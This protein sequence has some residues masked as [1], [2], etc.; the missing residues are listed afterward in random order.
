MEL[1]HEVEV[2][3]LPGAY[4]EKLYEVTPHA[5]LRLFAEEVEIETEIALKRVLVKKTVYHVHEHAI[6]KTGYVETTYPGVILE[7]V[8]AGTVGALYPELAPY[9][10]MAPVPLVA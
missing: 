2:H 7:G 9:T 5:L 4:K 8:P 6:G 10:Y 1:I 3:I